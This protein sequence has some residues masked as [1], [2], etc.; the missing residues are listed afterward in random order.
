MLKNKLI[1]LILLAILVLLVV[2]F[3]SAE[4]PLDE[5]L[6]ITVEI[7]EAYYTDLDNDSL[8]DDVYASVRVTIL[9]TGMQ[10]YDYLV[11]LEL[12]SGKNFSYYYLIT[13]NVQTVYYDNHFLDHAIESGWYK[14]KASAILFTSNLAYSESVL[15]FDPPGGASGPPP[16]HTLLAN[17]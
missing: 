14:I 11:E 1:S 10:V 4:E 6:S 7:L 15:I 9:P 2:P 8:E 17:Y 3:A 12:P 13:T 5:P 16:S